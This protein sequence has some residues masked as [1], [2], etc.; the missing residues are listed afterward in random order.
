MVAAFLLKAI[1]LPSPFCFFCY[2]FYAVVVL[3]LNLF[4]CEPFLVYYALSGKCLLLFHLEAILLASPFCL[5]CSFCQRVAVPWLGKHF[6]GDLL[7]LVLAPHISTA[8]C[9]HSFFSGGHAVRY[10]MFFVTLFASYWIYADLLVFVWQ[11]HYFTI[12]FARSC[13]FQ[14]NA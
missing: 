8:L 9:C 1:S 5:S 11:G 13:V 2:L 3:Y 7:L 10:S 14:K 12:C 6:V 4:V